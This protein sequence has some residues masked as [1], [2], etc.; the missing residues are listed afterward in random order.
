MTLLTTVLVEKSRRMKNYGDSLFP[1][2]W[3]GLS[4]LTL[5]FDMRGVE[6]YS[7]DDIRLIAGMPF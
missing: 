5:T 7:C 1:F 4:A 2:L 6:F 3:N